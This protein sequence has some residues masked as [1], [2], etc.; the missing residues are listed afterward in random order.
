MQSS[1]AHLTC[2]LWLQKKFI[3]FSEEIR[4]W[5]TYQTNKII[6]TTFKKLYETKLKIFER[7]RGRLGILTQV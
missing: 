4:P 7:A 6:N 5:A 2:R 1:F 3:F